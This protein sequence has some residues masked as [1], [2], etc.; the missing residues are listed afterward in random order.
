MPGKCI[1]SLSPTTVRSGGDLL[2][3]PPTNCTYGCF[4]M[5]LT[6]QGW[7]GIIEPHSVKYYTPLLIPHKKIIPPVQPDK[8]P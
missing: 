2:R 4:H 1:L 3:V 7:N 6:N 8:M 5:S